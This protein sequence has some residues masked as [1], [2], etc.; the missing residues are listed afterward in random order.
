MVDVGVWLVQSCQARRVNTKMD[1]DEWLQRGGS[2]RY[3]PTQARALGPACT[4]WRKSLKSSS[5][6]SVSPKSSTCLVGAGWSALHRS[7]FAPP[8]FAA[9]YKIIKKV[10]SL[11]LKE[12]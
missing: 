10:K 9:I 3:V 5:S 8:F 6:T 12:K 11:S 4:H 7:L 1:W 2:V